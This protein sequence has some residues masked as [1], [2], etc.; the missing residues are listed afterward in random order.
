MLSLKFMVPLHYYHGSVGLPPTCNS[1]FLFFLS[2]SYSTGL[3]SEAKT[4]LW[5][6]MAAPPLPPLHADPRFL[7]DD[8]HS[9][10]PFATR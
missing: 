2:I 5:S 10:P 4:L 3:A 9:A 6:K 8:D 7:S 1:A